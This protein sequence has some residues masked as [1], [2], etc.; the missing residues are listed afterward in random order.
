MVISHDFLLT[1][2]A[3]RQSLHQLLKHKPSD[4]AQQ[5]QISHCDDTMLHDAA[6]SMPK[7]HIFKFPNNIKHV[8]KQYK[9]ARELEL[10]SSLFWNTTYIFANIS[11][12]MIIVFF[13][14]HDITSGI[15]SIAIMFN[16]LPRISFTVYAITTLV[17]VFIAQGLQETSNYNYSSDFCCDD[18]KLALHM[19]IRA[20]ICTLWNVFFAIIF[21]KIL[22]Q[23]K[24]DGVANEQNLS[25]LPAPDFPSL[26]TAGAC[27][28]SCSSKSTTSDN[29]CRKKKHNIYNKHS[30][31]INSETVSIENIGG[32]SVVSVAL[33]REHY[34]MKI[35]Y[36]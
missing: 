34:H 3:F 10:I 2:K 9:S 13:N 35:D 36:I 12:N 16:P 11:T 8:N 23:A 30:D 19:A 31:N 5:V 27:N 15:R 14:L 18:D 7:Q 24:Q 33:R 25:T 17:Y 6:N 22:Q 29:R 20:V 32:T 21:V 4:T 1:M 28:K 26:I